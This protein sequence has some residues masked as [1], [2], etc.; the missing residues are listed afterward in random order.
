MC[1]APRPSRALPLIPPRALYPI[2]AT[3]R[4]CHQ[5][6]HQHH[7]QPQQPQRGPA[8]AW[9][10]RRG[11]GAGAAAGGV[12]MRRR[13]MK[14]TTRT[15]SRGCELNSVWCG[16]WMV[17]VVAQ[18]GGARGWTDPDDGSHKINHHTCVLCGQQRGLRGHGPPAAPQP[19]PGR[20]TTIHCPSS[21]DRCVV[22]C[23]PHGLSY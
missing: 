21:Y 12:W 8:C 7:S 13:S 9:R 19:E 16:D 6:C 17:E 2:T 1:D 20:A 5:Q 23:L 11:A 18:C 10:P 22:A 15:R 3:A 4:R 14:I